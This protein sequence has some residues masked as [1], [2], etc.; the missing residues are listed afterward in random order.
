[1]VTKG[2]RKGVYERVT[3]E[4]KLADEPAGVRG[5]AIPVEGPAADT[6]A[7]YRPSQVWTY[8]RAASRKKKSTNSSGFGSR[9]MIF[10][11]MKLI[12]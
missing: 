8:A 10:H 9:R 5:A 6:S 12:A 7:I 3:F 4:T 11:T 2:Y 1:M